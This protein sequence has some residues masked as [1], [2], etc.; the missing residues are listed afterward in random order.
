VKRAILSFVL[1]S[2]FSFGDKSA[3]SEGHSADFYNSYQN[4]DTKCTVIVDN[5]TNNSNQYSCKPSA[6]K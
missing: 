3:W 4:E 2:P 1:F 5:I 6:T